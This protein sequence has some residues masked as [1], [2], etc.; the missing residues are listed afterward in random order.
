MTTGHHA[1]SEQYALDTAVSGI[2]QFDRLYIWAKAGAHMVLHRYVQ[3]PLSDAQ[4]PDE[5]LLYSVLGGSA[6]IDACV[7]RNHLARFFEVSALKGQSIEL[8]S[9]ARGQIE[10]LGKLLGQAA[11][12]RLFDPTAMLAAIVG[13]TDR[14][15]Y[16]ATRPESFLHAVSRI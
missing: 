14:F 8:H 16:W 7:L 13:R 15:S 1:S 2:D 3:P 9:A 4:G 12:I 6:A 10:T 5:T 11:Q